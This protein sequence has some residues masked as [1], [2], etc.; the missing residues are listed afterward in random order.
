MWQWRILA[1]FSYVKI[2]SFRVR[3]RHTVQL[4]NSAIY[5]PH[6]P[7]TM[8]MITTIGRR[9]WTEAMA[10]RTPSRDD[11][12]RRS[13]RR[14]RFPTGSVK[15]LGRRS[16]NEI[17]LRGLRNVDFR[18]SYCRIHVQKVND[19]TRSAIIPNVLADLPAEAPN[20]R[21]VYISP[22]QAQ[23]RFGDGLLPYHWYEIVL[24]DKF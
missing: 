18:T 10:A 24:S 7:T 17:L 20:R 12:E 6:P 8:M 13:H 4:A 15:S 22:N 9:R 5:R 23:Q 16:P 14:K 1:V 11:V 2:M 19:T 21:T 3:P